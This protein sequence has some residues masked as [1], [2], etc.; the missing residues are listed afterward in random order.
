MSSHDYDRYKSSS[1]H[2]SS[3]QIDLSASFPHSKNGHLINSSAMFSSNSQSD[4]HS[5]RERKYYDEVC[6]AK[7]KCSNF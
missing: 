2:H 4:R 5:S 3:H 6:L 1:R 7:C